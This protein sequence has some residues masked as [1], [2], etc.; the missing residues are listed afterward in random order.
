MKEEEGFEGSLYEAEVAVAVPDAHGAVAVKYFEIFA[1]DGVQRES[2]LYHPRL[3]R[4]QQ[5]P[6]VTMQLLRSTVS[7]KAGPEEVGAVNAVHLASLAL[8]AGFYVAGRPV[9]VWVR[10]G[11][12]QASIVR[13]VKAEQVIRVARVSSKASDAALATVMPSGPAWRASAEGDAAAPPA[14]T[15]VGRIF[16]VCTRVAE[17]RVV[18]GRW[19]RIPAPPCS[20]GELHWRQLARTVKR[21]TRRREV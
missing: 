21:R 19:M 20:P 14:Q 1:E 16:E 2:G 5:S 11:W 3:L 7:P 10:G 17:R 9:D 6:G 13:E 8:A 12:W 15:D 18:L 4:P